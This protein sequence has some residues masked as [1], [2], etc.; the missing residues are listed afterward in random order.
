MVRVSLL[1]IRRERQK[2]SLL[3]WKRGYMH[4]DNNQQLYSPFV[5]PHC[6]LEKLLCCLPYVT[7][8]PNLRTFPVW[9]NVFVHS[10]VDNNSITNEMKIYI[11]FDKERR[12]K[13]NKTP[14]R[15]LRNKIT[16]WT[17]SKKKGPSQQIRKEQN[18]MIPRDRKATAIMLQIATYPLYV[19]SCNR[20]YAPPPMFL[21][22]KHLGFILELIFLLFTLFWCR[23]CDKIHFRSKYSRQLNNLRFEFKTSRLSVVTLLNN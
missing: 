18:L 22:H 12:G 14:F 8:L 5:V 17:A 7:K 2:G 15:P 9:K 19:V 10:W 13:K 3:V 16:N 21:F 23:I 11:Y 1:S 20:D 6:L 4:V